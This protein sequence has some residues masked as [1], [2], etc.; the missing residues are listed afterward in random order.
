MFF[1]LLWS[2]SGFPFL[3]VQ[4]SCILCGWGVVDMNYLDRIAWKMWSGVCVVRNSST[5]QGFCYTGSKQE[6]Q[7]RWQNT[8][9]GIPFKT[10][11]LE[12]AIANDIHSYLAPPPIFYF[13]GKTIRWKFVADI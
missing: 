11:F 8:A 4:C 12:A 13:T 1:Y 10:L 5:A 6:A 7:A 2:E 3:A 9:R